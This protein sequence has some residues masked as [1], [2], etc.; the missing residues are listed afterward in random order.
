MLKL[1]ML[2]LVPLRKGQTQKEAIGSMLTLV[3]TGER[4]GYERYW[5]ARHHNISNLLSLATQLLVSHILANTQTIRVSTGGVMLPNCS[6]L[7]AAE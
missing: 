7:V 4:V 6:P 5:V 3:Q 1:S 2:N